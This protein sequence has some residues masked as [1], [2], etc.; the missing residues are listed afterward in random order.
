MDESCSPVI[1][2]VLFSVKFTEI[3]VLQR[4]R[5]NY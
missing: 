2:N 3:H 1:H 5:T 4:K